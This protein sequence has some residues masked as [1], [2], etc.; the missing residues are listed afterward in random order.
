MQKASFN[1]KLFGIK[2]FALFGAIRLSGT[3]KVA[4]VSFNNNIICKLEHA[5]GA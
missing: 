3:T 1:S 5:V 4:I 2:V